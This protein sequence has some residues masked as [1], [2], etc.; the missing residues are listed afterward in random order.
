MTKDF[1]IDQVLQDKYRFKG[2]FLY[3]QINDIDELYNQC[4]IINYITLQE[5]KEGKVGH[6]V[7]LDA[8][9]NLKKGDNY[10]DLYYFDPYGL[11]PDIGRKYLNLPEG[12]NI[13]R[14]IM[15][16]N[17]KNNTYNHKEF[18]VLQ[19]YDNLCGVY[20]CLYVHNPNFR[21]NPIFDIRIPYKY[22]SNLDYYLM[23]LFEKLGFV[24]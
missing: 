12:D 13:T 23:A 19:P 14:L 2:V 4:I 3:D 24:V 11:R 7:V 18:Q 21:T 20:S 22:R 15:R 5:G 8:R 6:F 10:K 9:L 16:T 17:L 1:S